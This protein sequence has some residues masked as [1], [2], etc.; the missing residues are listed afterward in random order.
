MM[1]YDEQV[2]MFK[3]TIPIGPKQA[4]ELIDCLMEMV[5]VNEISLSNLPGFALQNAYF[6]ATNCI[7]NADLKLAPSDL[8]FVAYNVIR[9]DKRDKYISNS[10]ENEL[11]FVIFEKQTGYVSS[12]SD[13]LFLDLELVRG[14]SRREFDAE[15]DQ[16]RSLIA[17]RAIT[18]CEDKG[19]DC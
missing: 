2:E 10:L 9:N 11:L 6:N 4:P 19:L 15:G 14:V 8:S 18:Y 13:R 12:N 17:H 5:D 16:F 1:S 7:L 3:K